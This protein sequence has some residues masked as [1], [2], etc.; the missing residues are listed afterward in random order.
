MADMSVSRLPVYRLDTF[1]DGWA[2]LGVTMGGGGAQSGV[3]R[4]RFDGTRY[5]SNPTTEPLLPTVAGQRL[6]LA[7]TRSPGGW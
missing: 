4:L 5:P 3:A 6:L 1:S 7:D 2:D